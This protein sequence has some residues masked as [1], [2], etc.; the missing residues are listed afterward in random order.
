MLSLTGV[1]VIGE[2]FVAYAFDRLLRPGHRS[3]ASAAVR[4]R[5]V[6]TAVGVVASVALFV[7]A[8]PIASVV[9]L[10][11]RGI[12]NPDGP[13]PLQLLAVLFGFLMGACILLG[14][15]LPFTDRSVPMY[16]PY[17]DGSPPLRPGG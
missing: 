11:S 15:L 13:F 2:L 3:R 1:S 10:Q 4:F 16:Q 5:A 6:T 17:Q 14:S 7:A 9:F 8:S 12:L